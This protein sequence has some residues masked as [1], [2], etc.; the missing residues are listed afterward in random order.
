M[1]KKQPKKQPEINSNTE[2]FILEGGVNRKHVYAVMGIAVF[3]EGEGLESDTLMK[4]GVCYDEHFK[5]KWIRITEADESYID[6]GYDKWPSLRDAVDIL[7]NQAIKLSISKKA[8][9]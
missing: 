6:V 7:W 4:V 1:R 2:E 9:A 8:G 5:H 3:P